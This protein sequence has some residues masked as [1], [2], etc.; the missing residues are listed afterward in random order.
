MLT[1]NAREIQDSRYERRACLV[2][3]VFI[4]GEIRREAPI[5][6]IRKEYEY[7]I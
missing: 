6:E 2:I 4:T 7:K 1:V 5:M 3:P